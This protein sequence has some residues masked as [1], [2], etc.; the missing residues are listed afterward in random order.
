MNTGTNNS[1]HFSFTWS[2]CY[3][4]AI[5]AAIAF[6]AKSLQFFKVLLLHLTSALQQVKVVQ[7]GKNLLQSGKNH[8]K[9]KHQIHAYIENCYHIQLQVLQQKNSPS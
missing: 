9:F 8:L 2:S 4:Q 3:Q 1:S 5:F 7:S 6:Q